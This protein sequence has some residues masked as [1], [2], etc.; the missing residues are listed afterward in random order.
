MYI[1]LFIFPL[2]VNLFIKV[3]KFVYVELIFLQIDVY[4]KRKYIELY[5]LL[6]TLFHLTFIK[7]IKPN[8]ILLI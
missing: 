6:I 4:I 8:R 7:F 5:I 3:Y 1:F 2:Q